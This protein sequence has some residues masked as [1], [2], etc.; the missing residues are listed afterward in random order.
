MKVNPE[1]CEDSTGAPRSPELEEWVK[2]WKNEDDVIWNRVKL[3]L[4]SMMV[5]ASIFAAFDVTTFYTTVV[6]VLGSSLRPIFLY[7]TWRGFVYETTH[8]DSILKLIEAVYIKRHEEDLI[9]EEECYRMLAEI[10]RSPELLKA[11]SGSSLK[12]T[13]DPCLDRLSKADR[14]KIEHL[15]ILERKGFEV[16]K[17]KQ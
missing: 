7:G 10:I 12:G 8:P 5:S 13:V 4:F 6:L 17:L 1:T 3:T 2:N 9:G 15:E 11:I 14:Q 16:E